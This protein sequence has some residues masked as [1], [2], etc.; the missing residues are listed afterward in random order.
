MAPEQLSTQF[1]HDAINLGGLG[2][3]IAALQTRSKAPL[4]R[5]GI[6]DS[7]NTSRAIWDL[8]NQYPQANIAIDLQR[9][10]LL[11]IGPDSQEWLERFE[12]WG[13]P[14]TM[15]AVSG[16]GDGHLHFY[17]RQPEG[18]PIFRINRSGEYD[19][20]TGGYFVAP[21]SIHPS[22]KP[23]EWLTP[24]RP[25]TELP[26]AP[27]WAEKMLNERV[28]QRK[29]TSTVSIATAGPTKIPIYGPV[30][31]W[32]LGQ[33]V[34]NHADGSVDRSATLF[35]LA[36]R[37]AQSVATRESIAATLAERDVALGFEKYTGRADAALRYTELAEK[38]IHEAI[39]DPRNQRHGSLLSNPWREAANG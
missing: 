36:C 15:I 4:T 2:Y 3:Y 14:N 38:A 25:R 13:L 18:C 28:N 19:I 31:P 29:Q 37:L 1:Q 26:E 9:S 7:I 20:Q 33:R 32:Y 6:R 23:Y 8:W 17:Y 12:E 5:H 27:L 35:A 10:G 30:V 11:G 24:P 22:G 21:C 34:V 39:L 16:G